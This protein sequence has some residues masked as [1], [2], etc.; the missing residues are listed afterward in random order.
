VI[1]VLDK[2]TGKISQKLPAMK[3][4][5]EEHLPKYPQLHHRY[6]ASSLRNMRLLRARLE[7]TWHSTS[8]R[9]TVKRCLGLAVTLVKEIGIATAASR[10]KLDLNTTS[11]MDLS[12][13]LWHWIE[14]CEVPE[15]L[16]DESH[17]LFLDASEAARHLTSYVHLYEDRDL[18]AGAE[19][20]KNRVLRTNRQKT[21]AANSP[22]TPINVL[23]QPKVSNDEGWTTPVSRQRKQGDQQR[24]QLIKST[25]NDLA[26]ALSLAELLWAK[27]RD[28]GL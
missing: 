28:K 22:L 24:L 2:L 5:P 8:Y 17:H 25:L 23:V 26:S 20:I 19:E 1:G 9:T 10:G 11:P 4:A 27:F 3:L 18:D 14:T 7:K 21:T 13:D 16:I 12:S 6:L 15:E